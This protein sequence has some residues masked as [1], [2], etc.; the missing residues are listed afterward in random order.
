[1][2]QTI[3][4]QQTRRPDGLSIFAFM[5]GA[6]LMCVVSYLIQNG[7]YHYLVDTNNQYG[8][9]LFNSIWG[10]IVAI[11]AAGLYRWSN[12]TNKISSPFGWITIA[13]VTWFAGCMVYTFFIL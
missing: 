8:V 4:T 13:G 5:L 2:V 12:I 6:L 3:K 1:M 7:Y 10:V 9:W 11:L